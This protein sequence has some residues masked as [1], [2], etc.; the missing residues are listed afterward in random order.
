MEGRPHPKGWASDL[1]GKDVAAAYW[2]VE[3][4]TGLPRGELVHNN[5]AGR[6]QLRRGQVSSGWW[7]AGVQR[8]LGHHHWPRAC[9][10]VGRATGRWSMGQETTFWAYSWGTAALWPQTHTTDHLS[11]KNKKR[12]NT[13]H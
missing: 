10:H 7:C 4:F 8:E 12:E 6:K 2:M 11:S 1:T 9:S 3:K 13:M 5:W